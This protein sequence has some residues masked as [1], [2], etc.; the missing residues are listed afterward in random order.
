MA[1]NN[2]MPA[3]RFSG[4][5]DAWEQRKL[6]DLVTIRRGLTYKPSD[7]AEM[8]LEF[9]DPRTLMRTNLLRLMMMYL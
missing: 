2:K 7:I 4:Y 3:I 5:T 6:N 9:C 1:K 8:V